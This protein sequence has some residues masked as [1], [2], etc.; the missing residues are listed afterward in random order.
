VFGPEATGQGYW[1]Y[2]TVA[3]KDTG[4]ALKFTAEK[5]GQVCRIAGSATLTFAFCFDAIPGCLLEAVYAVPFSLQDGKGL[6]ELRCVYAARQV[7]SLDGKTAHLSGYLGA[8]G[9][10]EESKAGQAF[11]GIPSFGFDNS[12]LMYWGA[13]SLA[14]AGAGAG[15]GTPGR[16]PAAFRLAPGGTPDQS[17]EIKAGVRKS[18]A[19]AA[20]E[21]VAGFD[22][23]GLLAGEP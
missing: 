7:R 14:G 12:T 20:E 13:P 3:R 22:L 18:P 17:T 2:L 19:K 23:S 6:T 21:Q 9:P 10:E 5:H 15:A 16:N 4:S 8:V 1:P 11:A